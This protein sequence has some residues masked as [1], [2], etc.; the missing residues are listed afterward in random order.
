[1]NCRS[2]W[3]SHCVLSPNDIGG[4]LRYDLK[5]S[6]VSRRTHTRKNTISERASASA[7]GKLVTQ[8]DMDLSRPLVVGERAKMILNMQI[9]ND[10]SFLNENK[11]MDYSLLVGIHNC[12]MMC[13][14]CTPERRK[15]EVDTDGKVREAQ[16]RS[17]GVRG[18]GPPANPECP[19]SVYFFGIIDLLQ[20]WTS[21]K[22]LERSVKVGVASVSPCKW[23]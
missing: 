12:S 1:M 2:P 21:K 15:N 22:K 13:E 18:A 5:G 17:H 23:I 14:Q 3:F 8:K 9:T 10:I 11:L 4:H 19:Q 6:N 16:I 7:V 20:K